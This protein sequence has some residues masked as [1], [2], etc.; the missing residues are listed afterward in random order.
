MSS[1][2]FHGLTE[3]AISTILRRSGLS[4]DIQAVRFPAQG[5]N[6]QTYLVTTMDGG[7]AVIKVRPGTSAGDKRAGLPVVARDNPF[8]P[9]Y[10]QALFGRYANGGLRTLGTV[11]A[12]LARHGGLRVPK[13]YRVD[14]TCDVVPAPYLVAERVEG[15]GF[16]WSGDNRFTPEAARQ[17]GRHLAK[18]HTATAG[19]SFGIFSRHGDFTA[20]EWWDRFSQ[21]YRVV[22]SDLTR[23]NA[24]LGAGRPAMEEALRRAV[25]TGTPAD[26]ALICIDQAPTHYLRADDGSISAMVDVEGHLWAPAAYEL[27]MVEIWIGGGTDGATEKAALRAGYEEVALYPGALLDAV[28]P[29]YQLMTWMEWA[30]C[31]RTLVGDEAGALSAEEQLAHLSAP[32]AP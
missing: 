22:F 19:K 17:L 29:A 26:I 10:T 23:T 8:W 3:G 25:A 11:T 9:G 12:L 5:I 4:G 18:V 24:D 21:A 28:R 20:Q 16:D 30:W 32:F 31:S 6:N 14:E 27:A 7:E 2:A 1:S 15:A 13:V